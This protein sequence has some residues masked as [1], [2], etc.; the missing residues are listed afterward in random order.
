MMCG[1][2]KST[3]LTSTLPVL[4]ANT[5]F[6]SAYTEEAIVGNMQVRWAAAGVF[7]EEFSRLVNGDLALSLSAMVFVFGYIWFHTASLWLASTAMAQILLSLPVA[8]FIYRVF[9]QISY[10][11]QL[12]VLVSTYAGVAMGFCGYSRCTVGLHSFPGARCWC[13]RCVCVR[14][15]L[16]AERGDLHGRVGALAL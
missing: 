7:N 15:R 16:E 11:T 5:F 6:S 10:F 9:F 13:G 14:G 4:A 2:C 12:H 3:V 8:F 1:G